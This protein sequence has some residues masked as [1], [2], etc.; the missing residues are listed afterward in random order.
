VS[1]VMSDGFIFF[2]GAKKTEPKEST[3]KAKPLLPYQR[4][5]LIR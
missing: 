2:A 3:L 1:S 4:E 5:G